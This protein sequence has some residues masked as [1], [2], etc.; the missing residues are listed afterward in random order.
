MAKSLIEALP[1]IASE[2]RK[3]A[4]QIL[5]RLSNGTQIGLQTNEL[6]LPSKDT[7]GLFRGS[8]PQIPNAFN[9]ALHGEGWMNRLIYGD[10]LLTMQALLAGD[11]ATGL[12]SMRGKVDL[13]YIDPPFDSKADYRTKITLPGA[14][15]QQKPTVIE[16]FAYADTWEEGTVSYLHMM[17]PRLVLMRELLSDRGSIYVHIDWHVGHYVKILMDEIF[18]KDNF[19]NEIIWAYSRWANVSSAF[20][21][22]HDNIFYY[23][24]S[25]NSIFH[26]QRIKLSESR[27]R[28]LVQMIDGIKVSMRDENGNVVY[29]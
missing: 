7:S 10:N 26:E 1:R 27:K 13:I 6:V 20:Q 19:K 12:P 14:D 8:S 23:G 18:G 17:Y 24:R 4:Q 2:G 29:R 25:S 11:P 15:I 28:N 16:Q 5:E 3:E 21:R 9:Q 22:M